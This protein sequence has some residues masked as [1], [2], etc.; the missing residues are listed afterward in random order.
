[1]RCAED[2]TRA[3]DTIQRYAA[4]AEALSVRESTGTDCRRRVKKGWE[5]SACGYI[6]TLNGR[7]ACLVLLII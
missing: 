5:A 7:E 4:T 6:F 1:M 2:E 3:A